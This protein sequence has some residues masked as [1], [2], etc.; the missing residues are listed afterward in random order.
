M[1]IAGPLAI[2]HT[3][4]HDEN[5]DNS[6]KIEFAYTE[7]KRTILRTKNVS[8]KHTKDRCGTM[9]THMK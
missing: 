9:E 3:V 8:C 6:R 7:N 5:V 2:L 1:D 4:S